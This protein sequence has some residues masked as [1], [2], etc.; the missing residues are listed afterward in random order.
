[1]IIECVVPREGNEH[2]VKIENYRHKFKRNEHGAMVCLIHNEEHLKWMLS[3]SSYR[4][5]VP[6]KEEDAGVRCSNEA[7]KAVSEV[8]ETNGAMSET[9]GTELETEQQP[10]ET[11]KKG[12]PGK[13]KT[14]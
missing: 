11:V 3:S 6:P 13:R 2:L 10:D 7:E 5:Y 9:A 14:A 8:A 12:K 4:E 1:M